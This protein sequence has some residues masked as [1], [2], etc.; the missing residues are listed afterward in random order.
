M[1]KLLRLSKSC[2]GEA[3]QQAVARVLAAEHLGMGQEVG[4]FEEELAAYIGNDREVICVTTGTA[5]LQLALQAAGIGPGDEVLAPTLTFVASFQAISATGATAVACDVDRETGFISLEDMK[6]K[7][8][9]KTRAVM[10]V[11]YASHAPGL[12]GVYEFAMEHGLRVV[13]DAAHAFGSIRDGDRIGAQGD[14]VCF[15]FDGIKNITSGEGGAVVT[16]DREAAARIR[17]ARLLGVE[18]DTEKRL[19][20]QRSWDFEVHLQ[21]WRYHM[22]NIMASIGREQLRRIETFQ[23]VRQK[24]WKTYEA[25]L[26][27][28]EKVQMMFAY[29]ASIHPHITPIRVFG[30]HRDALRQHL[31]DQR[32]ECGVHYKP[33]HLLEL[34]A[35]AGCT[36]AEALYEELLTLPCHADMAKTDAD[37]VLEQI[38]AFFS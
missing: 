8:T 32:I 36:N 38:R 16:S 13:E 6:R 37:R 14:L 30:G 11:Y 9:G 35:A 12:G 20:G 25:G 5:A 2:I 28:Q 22:S 34:Y 33:N 3:E 21:G 7:L 26:D 23:S 10:P 24:I 19:A 29:D 4:L 31:I 15:S 18:K 27:G 1:D 17:D